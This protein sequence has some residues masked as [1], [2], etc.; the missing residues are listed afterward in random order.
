LSAL[1]WRQCELRRNR[2]E[3]IDKLIAE[4]IDKTVAHEMMDNIYPVIVERV[5]RENWTSASL[6][7]GVVAG[8]LSAVMSGAGWGWM[9]M[10]SGYEIGFVVWGIGALCGYAVV[11]VTQGKKGFPSRRSVRL[12]KI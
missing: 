11:K 2:L 3:I 1:L 8:V 10:K 7:L 12:S 4:G 9:V 5:R 6:V